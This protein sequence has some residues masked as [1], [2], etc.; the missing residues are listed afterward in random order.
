MA[1]F[2]QQLRLGAGITAR[3]MVLMSCAFLFMLACLFCFF[4]PALNELPLFF[5]LN[6]LPGA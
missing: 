6:F 2:T 3:K 1:Q 4:V 5:F